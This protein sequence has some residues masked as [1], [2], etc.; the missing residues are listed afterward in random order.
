MKRGKF[1]SGTNEA[2]AARIAEAAKEFDAGLSDDLNTARALAAIFDLV[3]EA[4]IAID[5]EQFRQGDVPAT[6]EVLA[7]FDRV[8]A[9]MEDNDA[10]KLRALGYCGS[11]SGPADE[12]IDRLVDER[13]AAK[14]RR[15]FATADR[16]RKEL[17]D[18]GIMIEDAKDGSVRWKRK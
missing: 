12:E 10:E 7:N 11:E 2:M 17:A 13:N 15:D 16:I 9:V 8:F 6:L 3:R 18:R 1:P 14:K 5:K 4:N